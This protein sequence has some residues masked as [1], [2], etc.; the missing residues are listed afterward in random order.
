M[1]QSSLT[2]NVRRLSDAGIIEAGLPTKA[3]EPVNKQMLI[4]IRS[5]PVAENRLLGEGGKVGN[6]F[7]N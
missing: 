2:H 4:I 6:R 1:A 7:E 5:A 3:Q